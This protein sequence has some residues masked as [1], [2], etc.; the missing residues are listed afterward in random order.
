MF[1]VGRVFAFREGQYSTQSCKIYMNL[2]VFF[3]FLLMFHLAVLSQDRIICRAQLRKRRN[4]IRIIY[5]V[6]TAHNSHSPNR[7]G[8]PS[9]CVRGVLHTYHFVLVAGPLT[10]MSPEFRSRDARSSSPPATCQATMFRLFDP[11]AM[12]MC[13]LVGGVGFGITYYINTAV[14]EWGA[15]EIVYPMMAMVRP[16]ETAAA[17]GM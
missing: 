6:K 10:L 11:Y 1:S 7:S 15:E 17:R 3:R 8:G 4:H 5:F 16:L 13:F 12:A 14:T 9:K 2:S